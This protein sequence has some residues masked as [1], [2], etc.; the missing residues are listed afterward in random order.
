MIYVISIN[1]NIVA[2]VPILE[3]DCTIFKKELFYHSTKFP[4]IRLSNISID[5]RYWIC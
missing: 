3:K 5:T 1:C 4:N 2:Y